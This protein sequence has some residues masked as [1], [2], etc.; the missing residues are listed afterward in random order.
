MKPINRMR[1]FNPWKESARGRLFEVF[2]EHPDEIFSLS[3]VSKL[4]NIAK[5][6]VGA[7][8]KEFGSTNIIH[9]DTTGKTWRVSA[10][11]ESIPFR[12]AK[13][14]YALY[15]IYLSG[16]VDYIEKMFKHP[17][18]I[19]LF[20]SFQKG[21]DTTDSDIDI[22]I[23]TN[24]NQPYQTKMLNI[25]KEIYFV[26]QRKV[27]IHIFHRKNIDIHVFNNISNGTILSGFLEVKP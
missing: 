14:V 7:L 25:P 11:R 24:E 4:G 15:I 12:N 17:R 20:G 22:A 5:P 19:I 13:K 18:T 6:D 3:E 27:Q 10:N 26:L 9:L 1:G 21:D 8:L 2:F 23:E 16:I